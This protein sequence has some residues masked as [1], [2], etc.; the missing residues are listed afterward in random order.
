[1]NFLNIDAIALCYTVCKF[2]HALLYIIDNNLTY[3]I[4]SYVFIFTI[5]IQFVKF[6]CN[7]HH[8]IVAFNNNFFD[9]SIICHIAMI[10]NHLADLF[11]QIDCI[12]LFAINLLCIFCQKL[13]TILIV[14]IKNGKLYSF[15]R[16]RL[17]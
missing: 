13:K 6:V 10:C 14:V 12:L 17:L 9:G 2:K 4:K 5:C 8:I 16:K 15:L 1:M 3:N 7:N 11:N